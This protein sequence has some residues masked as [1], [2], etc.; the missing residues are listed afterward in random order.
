ML[1]KMQS[2]GV[3]GID[4]FPVEVEV[5]AANTMN[6]RM[7]L[8][9]LPDASV[10]ESSD[11][12]EAALQNSGFNIPTLTTTVNLAPADRK[13]EGPVFEL[14]IALGLL[15]ALD[16]FTK[17]I[18]GK[19]AIVGELALDGRVRRIKGCLS[20]ALRCREEGYDGLI[21]PKGNAGE[22]GVVR[23]LNVIPV[24]HLTDAM[25]FLSGQKPIHPVDI[26]LEG[27]FQQAG[28]YAVDFS[29][30]RGQE[31][32]K[33][34]LEIAA[35]GSHNVLMIGPPG[36]GKSM[37]AQRM[38]TILPKMDFEES[39]E[40]TR[41][42]SI[43]GMLDESNPLLAVR[44]FRSPHHTISDA[45][46]VGGGSN[47][48]PG[49][50]SLAHHGILFLDE[51]PE[52]RRSALETLRQ[53][54]EDGE[55]TIS[56]ANFS[57]TY[58]AQ[59]MLVAAMNP[60]KCGYLGHPRK[61]CTCSSYNIRQYRNRISGPLLDRID[62]QMNVPPVEYRELAS[63]RKAESSGSI[64]KRIERGR[65][66]QQERFKGNS[67]Y[68][69]ARMATR[70]IRKYCTLDSTCQNLLKQAMDQLGM[71]ARAYNKILKISRTI[72]DLESSEMIKPHHITESISYRTFDRDRI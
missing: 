62:I 15:E 42:Y 35:A 14:P 63:K 23:G 40:T 22:A 34:A 41:V 59:F 11:R 18:P 36:S 47:P 30:V 7:T 57:I 38:C 9:G 3:F 69:N 32:A 56:R 55:A 4:A 6:P 68:S 61:E 45:G 1:G 25:D 70:H 49:E 67:C 21:V 12:V 46:L 5:Y 48:K 71:S 13:K 8:V 51:L 72:A 60:C 24:N 20:M 50:I 19:Y 58:P 44:P 54:L 10:K 2:V 52:F 43:G 28:R 65:M 17:D 16:I 37:L 66:M 29:E 27:L 26:D 64:R 31:H 39:L 53:P 33:R